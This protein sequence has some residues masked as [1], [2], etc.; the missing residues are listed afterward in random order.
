VL[1][2]AA[3]AH[4][5]CEATSEA[6]V[7]VARHAGVSRA[8][9][10]VTGVDGHAVVEVRDHGRGFDLAQVPATRHGVRDSILHRLQDV[11][12]AARVDSSPGRGTTVRLEW[13][14]D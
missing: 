12:G 10:V 11:G 9:V 8:A 5:L 13:P 14:R 3:V 6:L 2:P 4:A 7:N 1:L